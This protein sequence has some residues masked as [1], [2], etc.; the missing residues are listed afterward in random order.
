METYSSDVDSGHAL[1]ILGARAGEVE[2][3]DEEWEA[4]GETGVSDAGVRGGDEE[5]SAHG[6]CRKS[7]VHV[8][9]ESQREG[10]RG[11]GRAIEK[12]MEKR[13][14]L[15]VCERVQ[16]ELRAERILRQR[17]GEAR[18]VLMVG[19]RDWERTDRVDCRPD[20]A[21]ELVLVL[22]LLAAAAR[23]CP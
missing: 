11:R 2:E 3:D 7:I 19:G 13:G 23:S 5:W 16:K 9:E 8:G 14:G 21:S 12:D 10:E 1:S 17:Q 4:C 20:R 15:C 18:E 22:L 6:V